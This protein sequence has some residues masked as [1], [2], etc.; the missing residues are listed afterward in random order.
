LFEGATIQV[1]PTQQ[2]TNSDLR[3]QNGKIIAIGNLSALQGEVV[4]DV[5]GKYI[6]PGFIDLDSDYGLPKSTKKNKSH[7]PQY[8]TSAKGPYGW[9]EAIKPEINAVQHLVI[10][11]KKA[12]AYHA[13]GFTN[14]LTHH[15][16]GIARGTGAFVHLRKSELH[17]SVD[18]SKA[19]A[20]FSF[21]KGSS[22]QQYP[23]SLMGI[24]AL[25]RQTHYDAE[26]YNSIS[27]NDH[28]N[29]SLE[30]WNQ[31]KELPWF[32]EV[33]DALDIP[34]ATVLS[35]ELNQ[36]FIIRGGNDAYQVIN[37]IGVQRLIVPLTIP[38]AL[39][40]EDPLDAMQATT[41][42]LKHWDLASSNTAMLT[43]RGIPISIT[44]N[45]ITKSSEFFK[46]L[47]RAVQQGLSQ[48]EALKALT[49]TPASW[50]GKTDVG[51][52]TVGF[53]SNF[54]I[55]SQSIF[56]PNVEVLAV[57]IQDEFIQYEELNTLNLSGIFNLNIE[58]TVYSLKLNS[59]G[60]KLEGYV[61]IEADTFAVKGAFTNDEVSFYHSLPKDA[62]YRYSGKPN[63]KGKILDGRLQT[64]SG[65]WKVWSAVRQGDADNKTPSTDETE[66]IQAEKPWFPNVAFGYDV[67][68]ERKDYFI[69]QVTIWT[70]DSNGKYLG[71]VVVR[72]G[73]IAEVGKNLAQT[74]DLEYIN[75][76]GMH[77]TP[78]IVDEHSHIAISRGVN[79]GTQASSAEVR[80]GDVVNPTDINIYRQLSGGV[81]TAQLLH[82]SANPIGGQ[83][84]LI[85]LKWGVSAETMKIDNASGFI[86]FA[87]GENVKQSNW[88]DHQKT[89]FPQ[90]RMGVEQVYYDHF[91]RAKKY[92]E[93]ANP[94]KEKGLLSFLQK[95]ELP[96]FRRDLELEALAEIL[97]STRFISCHSYVQSEI[98]MLMHVGDSMGF[99]VNTFTH[100]LEGYKLADKL[101]EH[102]AAGSTFADWWAYKFEVNDAIPYNAAI[103]NEQGV[104]TGINSDDAEMGR[105]LNQ[106]AA[107][108][109]KYGG[110]DEEDALK[111]VTINPATMLHL[112]DRI[113]SITIGK[114]A[115]L[116]LWTGHPL[117]VY[118]KVSFTMIEGVIYFS[119]DQHEESIT[120]MNHERDRIIQKMIRAKH[121]GAETEKVQVKNPKLYHCDT[122]EDEG[123]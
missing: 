93:V 68:P 1:S 94:V 45:G 58:G 33:K 64:S 82:G 29:L 6:Y 2:L 62:L 115:D 57:N 78:G 107:K 99:R 23:S 49:T 46:Q 101:A 41:A 73:K 34:R 26:W 89:R 98:N 8:Q 25:L 60:E 96:T 95:D 100:I 67:Q 79:E 106:E 114:D 116:V 74:P 16:D 112:E 42:Q 14:V 119:Q 103:L 75:G 113:G 3:I 83:S 40:V 55:T 84:A 20:H 31:S 19:S 81:T 50:L 111:M 43:Q 87:L 71:D 104:L 66:V 97:D 15:H 121:N 28:T 9:N 53:E 109:V 80:I 85:K 38:K 123:H 37:Q 86:K 22:K 77:L 117:S 59:K 61:L 36:P 72:D 13:M 52:L 5:T 30:A 10:D 76:K 90:T 118:S 108:T 122:D 63:F 24:I 51:Q 88:G 39:D 105:R 120:R 102:G 12:E 17:K 4:I 48:E 47:Q 91:I 32:F 21:S 56:E 18:E 11:V 44:S 54:F 35:E 27:E 70:C 69:D 110:V 65:D 92:N 7:I